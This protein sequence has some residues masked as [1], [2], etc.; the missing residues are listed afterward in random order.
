MAIA[1]GRTPF[2]LAAL[3]CRKQ[4]IWLYIF[5]Q[6]EGFYFIPNIESITNLWISWSQHRKNAKCSRLQPRRLWAL[7]SWRLQQ[8]RRWVFMHRVK[9]SD[10]LHARENLFHPCL[11]SACRIF[12]IMKLCPSAVSEKWTLGQQQRGCYISAQKRSF[13][14]PFGIWIMQCLFCLGCL[15]SQFSRCTTGCAMKRNGHQRFLVLIDVQRCPLLHLPWPPAS[16]EN[17]WYGRTKDHLWRHETNTTEGT[18]SSF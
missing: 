12:L 5:Y 3:Y 8:F 14:D 10:R 9:L 13:Q 1:E 4:A 17:R 6:S 11:L 18:P 16:L 2:C 15:Q 7:H